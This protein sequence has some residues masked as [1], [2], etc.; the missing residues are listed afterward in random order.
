MG[1]LRSRKKNTPGKL[2][3]KL[4]NAHPDSLQHLRRDAVREIQEG[5]RQVDERRTQKYAD[6]LAVRRCH[7]TRRHRS[8]EYA[9][10]GGDRVADGERGA[11][12]IRR[13]VDVVAQMPRRIRR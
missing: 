5:A 8:A 2:S 12:A 10:Y 13:D 6:P 9:G 7:Q 1:H 4:R 11:R 3:S